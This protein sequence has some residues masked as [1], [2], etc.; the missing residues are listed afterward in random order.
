MKTVV[1]FC[2][3]AGLTVAATYLF[4]SSQK[5]AQFARELELQRAGWDTERAELEAALNASKQR[6]SVVTT[7]TSEPASGRT[8]AHDVLEKLKKT[9]VL[10]GDQ[11]NR[12]VRQIVHYLESLTELGP[13]AVPAIREFLAKFEDVDYSGEVRDD[14]KDPMRA[15]E[16][17]DRTGPGLPGRN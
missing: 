2:V 7:V 6:S 11:R 12:S 8:T 13:E 5:S 10:P 1:A 14:D 17:K 16:S 4:V 9:K 15:A 3:A